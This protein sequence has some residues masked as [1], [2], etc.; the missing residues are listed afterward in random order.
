MPAV[1]QLPAGKALAV[2]TAAD[3]FLG[4]LGNPNTVRNCGIGVGVARR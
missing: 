3:A 1:V 2:R 4:S